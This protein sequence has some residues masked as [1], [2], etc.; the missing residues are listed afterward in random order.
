MA[1]FEAPSSFALP[2]VANLEYLADRQAHLSERHG[3]ALKSVDAKVNS[4]IETLFIGQRPL[5]QL[6]DGPPETK[7]G[8]N[9]AG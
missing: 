5:A 2:H 6:S 9:G 4:L 7:G 1:V 3:G 8:Q